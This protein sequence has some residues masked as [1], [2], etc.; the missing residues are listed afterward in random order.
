[1]WEQENLPDQQSLRPRPVTSFRVSIASSNKDSLRGS[2]RVADSSKVGSSENLSEGTRSSSWRLEATSVTHPPTQNIQECVTRPAP[3]R[4]SSVSR[5][6]NSICK[7]HKRLVKSGAVTCS[8]S[9]S[10]SP[11]TVELPP[12][13]SSPLPVLP[14]LEG[15]THFG[16]VGDFSGVQT[17]DPNQVTPPIPPSVPQPKPGVRGVSVIRS[18]PAALA[19]RPTPTS[20]PPTPTSSRTG[21]IPKRLSSTDP[22]VLDISETILNS[23][24]FRPDSLFPSSRQQDNSHTMDIAECEQQGV[25]L[26]QKQ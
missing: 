14:S 22:Q 18:A 8:V 6:Y 24:V 25:L 7:T 10:D 11:P 16:A 2:L 13:P 26:K 23:E 21:V 1:M 19:P 4:G 9:L 20:H 3:P 15:S 17:P 12:A 5:E